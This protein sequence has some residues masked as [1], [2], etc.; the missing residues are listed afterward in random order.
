MTFS[1]EPRTFVKFMWVLVIGSAAGFGCAR[2]EVQAPKDPIKMDISMRLDVYQH[3]V[4]DIDEIEN[5]VA[6][7]PAGQ[8]AWASFLVQTAY[9]ADLDPAVEAAAIRRRD[10]KWQVDSLLSEGF[11][12]ENY[13]GYL[14]VR[15][16]GNDA[17]AA[18]DAENADRTVIY[19][20]LAKKNG[21]TVGEIQKI[22]AEKLRGSAPGGSPVQST[23]GAWGTK[24]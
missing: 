7:K 8:L 12:G 5:I 3:V 21:T 24:N 14:E 20:S 10:R 22:Y 4:K 9:A 23:D 11:L 2:V 18:A 15:K 1:R 6:G 16:N 17:R 13:Q 19:E